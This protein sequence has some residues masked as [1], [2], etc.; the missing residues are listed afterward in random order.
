VF[1]GNVQF[2]YKD[3]PYRLEVG[4]QGFVMVSDLTSGE[5]TYGSG[6][7][8]YIELPKSSEKIILDFNYLYNPPCA[9]SEFTTCLYPPRQNQLAFEIKAGELLKNK[10]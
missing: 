10:R 8:M 2:S 9:F 6:R 1:I 4:E 7:Y 3:K 5:T